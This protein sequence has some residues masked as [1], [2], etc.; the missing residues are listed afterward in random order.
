MFPTLFSSFLMSLYMNTQ[1]IVETVDNLLGKMVS[2]SHS[3]CKV[4]DACVCLHPQKHH[5]T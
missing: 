3:L 4:L 5:F 1:D 2:R